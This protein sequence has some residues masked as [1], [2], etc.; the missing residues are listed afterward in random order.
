MTCR[1]QNDIK[2][3]A[4][5]NN[6]K[7]KNVRSNIK[8]MAYL[9]INWVSPQTKSQTQASPMSTYA[10]IPERQWQRTGL[11]LL[12][13]CV[14]LLSSSFQIRSWSQTSVYSRETLPFA[15]IWKHITRVSLLHTQLQ[16]R[17]NTYQQLG[18]TEG[19]F[20]ASRLCCIIYINQSHTLQTSRE[21][22]KTFQ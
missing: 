1:I 14:A 8:Y 4:K 2:C 9:S 13:M 7:T 18:R 17:E 10:P 22:V 6:K 3:K 19:K 12:Y 11:P 21:N 5:R 16:S 20:K 15:K